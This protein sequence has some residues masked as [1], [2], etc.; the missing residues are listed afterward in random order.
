MRRKHNAESESPE[1]VVECS[2]CMYRFRRKY[3]ILVCSRKKRNSSA[4]VK[5]TFQVLFERNSLA[6]LIGETP[7]PSIS[8][9]NSSILE[10]SE[11]RI[12]LCLRTHNRERKNVCMCSTHIFN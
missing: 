2:K 9:S 10:E 8:C 3:A 12:V 5:Y 6:I 1:K 7:F 11:K 4:K